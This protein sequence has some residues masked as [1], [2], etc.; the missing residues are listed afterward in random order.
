MIGQLF[1]R[2]VRSPFRRLMKGLGA[3]A[4]LEGAEMT[5]R[6]QVA[7][8]PERYRGKLRSAVGAAMA[9]SPTGHIN[10]TEAAR[11]LG[12]MQLRAA[13]RAVDLGGRRVRLIRMAGAHARGMR[14]LALAGGELAGLA[15]AGGLIRHQL[16]KQRQL[17]HEWGK[18]AAV[19]RTKNRHRD[20]FLQAHGYRG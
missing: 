20:A 4:R 5:L 3:K 11:L 13:N 19:T 18:K 9:N 1:R 16:K 2:A 7:K 15:I 6:R 14:T 17:Q 12:N 8:S 10:P